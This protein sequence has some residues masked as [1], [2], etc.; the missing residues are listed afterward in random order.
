MDYYSLNCPV[1]QRT[2]ATQAERPTKNAGK[3][4]AATF[5]LHYWLRPLSPHK[6]I[7]LLVHHS[8]ATLPL[9]A[10]PPGGLPA[11]PHLTNQSLYGPTV[12]PRRN[13]WKNPK[14]LRLTVPQ[15]SAINGKISSNRRFWA[16]TRLLPGCYPAATRLLPGCYPAATRCYLTRPFTTAA[17]VVS[18]RL[19][20]DALHP[21]DRCPSHQATGCICVSWSRQLL[22]FATPPPAQRG[23]RPCFSR[24]GQDRRSVAAGG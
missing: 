13:L 22:R 15:N 19:R 8:P 4:Y 10:A 17:S 9:R 24:R 23:P 1:C 3:G 16:A 2:C 18:S 6:P 11:C 12:A 20:G 5:I 7:S 14:V 21:T